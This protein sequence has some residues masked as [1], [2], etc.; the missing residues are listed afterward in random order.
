MSLAAPQFK[1]QPNSASSRAR[2]VWPHVWLGLA[3]LG[4]SL[5]SVHEH[6]I[7]KAGGSACAYTETISCDKVLSSAWAAPLGIPLGLFG[8]FFFGLIILTAIS[9]SPQPKPRPEALTRLLLA[10][11]GICGSL[12]LLYISKV[13][14]GAWCPICM[15]THTVVLLNFGFAAWNW[16]KLARR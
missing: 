3:G 15:A 16:K 5:F 8:A 14:I 7:V 11:V 10:S 9:T 13:L 12:G 1:P 4:I 2:V 6:N